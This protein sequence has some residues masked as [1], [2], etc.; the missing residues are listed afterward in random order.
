MKVVLCE[1]CGAT[2]KRYTTKCVRCTRTNLQFYH[3]DDPF[4][5]QKLQKI[6]GKREPGSPVVAALYVV[7]ITLAV[8][9]VSYGL[10]LQNAKPP[11]VAGATHSVP[12]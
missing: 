2:M 7:L 1:D 9:A 3:P 10:S 11:A 8:S 5:K 6:T 4:L 12:R